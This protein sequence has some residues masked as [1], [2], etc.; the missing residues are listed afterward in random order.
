MTTVA[1]TS[2]DASSTASTTAGGRRRPQ[3]DRAVT[4]GPL[5]DGLGHHLALDLRG[6]LEHRLD[7]GR[8]RGRPQPDRAVTRGALRL[9]LRRGRGLGLGLGLGLDDH[10]ALD[11]RGRLQHRLDHR[12]RRRGPQADRAVTVVT[13]RRG[14][15]SAVTS[16]STSEDASS[17]A[18]TTSADAAVRSRIVP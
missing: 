7:R 14:P 2:E 12:R 18:S 5:V 11:L 10:V 3:A 1:S 9:G 13:R 15:A 17:T 4:G 8:R 6:G 16:P